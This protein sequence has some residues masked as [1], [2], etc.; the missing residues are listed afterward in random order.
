MTRDKTTDFGYADIAGDDKQ[1]RVRG[2]F[3][4]VA[5]TYDLMNDAMSLGMH[6]IWKDLAITK[7]NPQPGEILVDVAGGTGDMARRFIRKSGQVRLRRGG[8][9]AKAV[10]CDINAE[11]L[12]A[13][14]DP[15]KDE[16]MDLTRVC[17]NAE[18]LP[19][20]DNYADAVT[21]AYGIRNITHRDMAL[22][23]FHRIL[24]PGGRLFILEFS[25][26]AVKSVKSLY[27]AYS[28]NVIPQL[29]GWIAGDRDSYRYL[30]ESIRLFPT[31]DQFAETVR[32]AGFIRVGWQDYC[33]GV[34]SLYWGWK[35]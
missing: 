4:S 18:L 28:F 35:I 15:R 6:R 25:T 27:D 13:G 8:E 23:E 9:P 7:V 32:Q 31:Q 29:G 26:P 16:G 3:D 14:V 34:T 2:V 33:A 19:F 20:R 30:I 10:I 22:S 11:M 12:F 21:I 17:A 1:S 24:K 5:P